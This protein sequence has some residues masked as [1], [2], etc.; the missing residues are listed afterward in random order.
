MKQ[1]IANYRTSLTGL[2]LGGL[3]WWQSTGCQIPQT[4]QEWTNTLVGAAVA[5]IGVLAKDGAT[6]SAPPWLHTVRQAARAALATL[7]EGDTGT[8]PGKEG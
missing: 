3:V 8:P 2:L 1:S 5:V 7:A 6:G 4:K